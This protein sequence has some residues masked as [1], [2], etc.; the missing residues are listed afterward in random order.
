MLLYALLLSL[1]VVA[2]FLSTIAAGGA[3]TLL[4]PLLGFLLGAQAVAP[5][6]SVACLCANPSR[7]WLFRHHLDLGICRWLLAGSLSGA[8]FGAMALTRISPD[9]TNVVIGLFLLSYVLQYRFGTRRLRWRLPVA[10][11]LPVGFGTA[12]ISGLVGATGPVLNPFLLNYGLRNNALVA[13]KAANSLLMQ[14]TKIFSYG[15]FGA[16]DPRLFGYGL[17]LGIGSVGGVLLARRHLH[18]ITTDRFTLY[19]LSLIAIAGAFMLWRGI[20][21]LLV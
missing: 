9:W 12:F 14:I 7:I 13:T 1:G 8:F 3:A 15:L 4:I 17:V 18:R 6:I 11:F 5:V 2:W 21:A 20:R 19:T 10:A 16:L